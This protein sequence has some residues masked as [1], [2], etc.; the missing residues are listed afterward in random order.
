MGK[1]NQFSQ[2]VW[3]L[4]EIAF[5]TGTFEYSLTTEWSPEVDVSVKCNSN[6]E[7]FYNRNEF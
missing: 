7:Q 5:Q 3:N 4:F 6:T 1:N 2:Q